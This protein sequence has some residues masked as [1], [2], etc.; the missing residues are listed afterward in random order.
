LGSG[1]LL[2]RIIASYIEPTNFNRKSSS[3]VITAPDRTVLAQSDLEQLNTKR[4]FKTAELET[5]PK[6][7]K[8]AKCDQAKSKSSLPIKLLN[9]VVLQDELKSIASVQVRSK[10]E[11]KS[12]KIGEKIDSMA[13]VEKINRLE[14]IIK[15]L[16]SG[17]CE[18][19]ENKP[20][21]TAANNIKLMNNRKAKK[22]VAESKEIKG[23]LNTGNDFTICKKLLQDK[24]KDIGAIIRQAKAIK[25]SNPDGTMS[26]KIVDI[27]PGSIYSFLGIED[28]DIIKSINGKPIQTLN[29]VMGMFTQ[30]ASVD[31]LNIGLDRDGTSVPRKYKITTCKNEN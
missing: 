25:L 3:T 13:K 21:M 15:N 1:F 22:F 2:A 14:V 7:E 8:I 31:S 24:L 5:A 16:R 27:E 26:F 17:Q 20:R 10:S 6:K 18:F 28:N 19:I 30:I 11:L 12:V 4:V 23:I 9:T 29:E